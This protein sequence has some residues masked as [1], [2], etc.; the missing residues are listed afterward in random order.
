MRIIEFKK[1]YYYIF[2][3]VFE[4]DENQLSGEFIYAGALTLECLIKCHCASVKFHTVKL[5]PFSRASLLLSMSLPLL[6]A[7]ALKM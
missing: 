2:N 4:I 1:I 5:T 6:F 7:T 3:F